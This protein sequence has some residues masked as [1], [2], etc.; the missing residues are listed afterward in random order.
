MKPIHPGLQLDQ[1]LDLRRYIRDYR[2]ALDMAIN[3]HWC[4]LSLTVLHAGNT[5]LISQFRQKYRQQFLTVLQS[6]KKYLNPWG[7]RKVICV[8]LRLGDV[9]HLEKYSGETEIQQMIEA[10]N[11][12]QIKIES[13]RGQAPIADAVILKLVDELVKRNPRHEVHFVASPDG[14]YEFDY[15]IHRDEDPDMDLLRLMHSDI[16]VLSRSSFSM[17]AGFFHLGTQVHCPRWAA[18]VQSGI[19]TKYDQSGWVSFKT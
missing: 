15:P 9:S 1:A 12:N 13:Y 8:H 14:P 7:K 10:V 16:L 4:N 5:D 3:N 17:L 6:Q 2:E 19:D 18:A 11:H